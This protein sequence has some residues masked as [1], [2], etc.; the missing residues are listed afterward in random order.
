[1]MGE[2]SGILFKKKSSNIQCM[3]GEISGILFKKKSSN[4][5][6]MMGEISR[7]FFKFCRVSYDGKDQQDFI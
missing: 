4:I 5:Q 3:I 2:I 7:I 6:C 1:M